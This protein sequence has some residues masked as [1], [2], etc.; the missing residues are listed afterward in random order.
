MSEITVDAAGGEVLDEAEGAG[1]EEGDEEEGH[2]GELP[3]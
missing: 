3:E 2:G 1:P